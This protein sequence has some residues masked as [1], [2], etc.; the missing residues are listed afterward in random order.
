M[1]LRPQ[2]AGLVNSTYRVTRAGRQYSLRVTADDSQDLGLDREWECRVLSVASAA[3]LAPPVAR[4][5][6]GEGIL[7]TSWVEGR[8]WCD[9]PITAASHAGR[10]AQLLRQVHALPIPQPARTMDA[11]AWVA[12]Y[13]AAAS[14]RGLASSPRS[15]DLHAAAQRQLTALAR[16]AAPA[17]VLCHSDVHRHNLLIADRAV[18]LDWEY[19]HVSDGF[20]DLAGWVANN[21][22]TPG[23]ASVLLAQYLSRPYALA[24]LARLSTLAWLYD[25]VCLLWSELYLWVR[26]GPSSASVAARAV[27]LSD[28]LSQRFS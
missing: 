11:G 19:A 1:A 20:W 7:V 16:W 5:E 26:P 6:P 17:A 12:H 23:E 28:R 14:R 21:D 2:S 27:L 25:Y 13:G 24:E 18:L 8:P 9:A 15:R 22:W 3:A 10:V 4:C